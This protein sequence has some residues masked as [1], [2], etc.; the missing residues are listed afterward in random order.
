MGMCKFEMTVNG[1]L[2]RT[3]FS[4]TEESGLKWCK[5]YASQFQ[6]K[7]INSEVKVLIYKKEKQKERW[8]YHGKPYLYDRTL[9][10]KPRKETDNAAD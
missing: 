3:Y 6:K 8:Q 2:L 1:F 9:V 7:V 10:K 5:R 4:E